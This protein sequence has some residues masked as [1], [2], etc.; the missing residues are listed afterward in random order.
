MHQLFKHFGLNT[1]EIQTF[2]RLLEL[3]AQPASIIAK[4]VGVPRS[5][6]YLILEE[7]KKVHLIEEFE[8]AKIKYF[9]CIPVANIPDVLKAQ[10]KEIQHT[11]EMFTEKLPELEAL[12]NKLSITPK[13]KF[14]EGEKAVMHMYE[15]VLRDKEKE[16]CAMFNADLAK[17]LVPDY[18]YLIPKMLQEERKKRKACISKKYSGACRTIC[19]YDGRP[20]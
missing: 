20:L 12:E 3:G 16:F 1:K 13:V 8:R 11:A 10:E 14:F 9:K 7:L 5:S 17:K 15:Q 19:L 4:H 2:L 6:M 18:Y